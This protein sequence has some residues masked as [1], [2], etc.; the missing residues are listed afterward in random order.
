MSPAPAPLAPPVPVLVAPMAGGPST[1]ELVAAV[2]EAGGSGY[3]SGGNLTPEA[4]ADQIARTRELTD[5][6]F[7]VNL[8]WYEPAEPAARAA[9]Q[10][11]AELLAPELAAL[12]VTAPELDWEDLDR[13][14]EKL[15]L[16]LS[17]P[18]AE[19]SFTFGLPGPEIV[20]RLHAA[21]TAVAA[22]VADHHAARCAATQGVDRLCVQGAEAGGHRGT[23]TTGE[24]PNRLTTTQL[25]Q[26]VV[27][28]L[29]PTAPVPLITAAGGVTDRAE[30]EALL[31]AGAES[32]QVGT[33]FL[34][35][36]EAGTSTAHAAALQDP[37]ITETVVTRAF[38]GRPARGLRSR[39]VAAHDAHAPAAYP[40]V[41][42]LTRPLRTAAA[43]AGDHHRV[44]AWAGT[45]WRQARPGPAAGVVEALTPTPAPGR[46]SGSR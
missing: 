43:R 46:P 25:V 30:I 32:V 44:S 18:V 29:G 40:T 4:L 7:G 16:L 37:E 28:A 8:F 41:N 21:G 11:Y 35:T 17:D 2:A 23:L 45:G 24:E 42:Q 14:S 26:Q 27:R 38:S 3:L 15:D 34:L 36:D 22:T 20:E 9:V 39:F 19:V 12:D 5:R 6:P 31:T 1:P 10:E 33:L 13:A